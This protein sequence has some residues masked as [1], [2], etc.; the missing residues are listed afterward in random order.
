V[1]SSGGAIVVSLPWPGEVRLRIFDLR[2]ELIWEGKKAYTAGGSY[3]E[4]WPAM[5]DSGSP[6]SYGAY[7]LQA[8]CESAHGSDSD[9]RWLSVVR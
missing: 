4:P 1:P 7:Y 3:Q 8:R 9:G 2:G 5:N 6:V